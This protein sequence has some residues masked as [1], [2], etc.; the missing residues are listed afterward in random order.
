[1]GSNV[2]TCMATT[3]PSAETCAPAE[4][5]PQ[6]LPICEPISCPDINEIP[7]GAISGDC[8]GASVGQECSVTCDSDGT[9][10]TIICQADGTWSAS[11]ECSVPVCPSLKPPEN[12][13]FT[14][15]TCAPGVIGQTCDFTC[16]DGYVLQPAES[17]QLMCQTGGTWSAN[18]P[19]C[20]AIQCEDI[21][22]LVIQNGGQ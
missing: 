7:D 11:L 13:D 22:K 14:E 16:S 9:K 1:M 15:N 18:P 4:W 20:V 2:L 5:S 19:E 6:E 17:A 8:I 10:S 3:N 21:T 12:G